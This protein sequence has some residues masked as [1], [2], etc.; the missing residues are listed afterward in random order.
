MASHLYFELIRCQIVVKI[1]KPFTPGG[2]ECLGLWGC[3]SNFT[4][5]YVYV[6]FVWQM[7]VLNRQFRYI[8]TDMLVY[9]YCWSVLADHRFICICVCVVQYGL[10]FRITMQK[11]MPNC[12][13]TEIHTK[14]NCY[15]TV[16]WGWTIKSIV[17]K[18][19]VM[20]YEY[21]NNDNYWCWSS[22]MGWLW[23]V[24]AK[25]FSVTQIETKKLRMD[26]KP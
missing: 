10:M 20:F 13:L 1:W 21:R 16:T 4:L 8:P 25:I 3:E 19:T 26:S 24:S 5:T 14:V 11:K 17:L 6:L 23:A 15:S 22:I 7:S 18:Y 9:W 2:S 12:Y